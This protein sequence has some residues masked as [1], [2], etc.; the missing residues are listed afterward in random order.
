MYLIFKRKYILDD[1]GHLRPG[2]ARRKFE[3]G[4]EYVGQH[5]PEGKRTG[6]GI[7][8]CK[9]G[10]RYFGDWKNNQMDG[11]GVYAF[12]S[13]QFYKGSLQ[14]GKKE[15]HGEMHMENG[16]IY[17]GE[18]HNDCRNGTGIFKYFSTG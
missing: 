7:M 2:I 17:K 9:N 3:N 14:K 11:E 1:Q 4:N 10:D 16:N 5:D 6:K 13:G 12:A 18:Y 15:G 8:Y